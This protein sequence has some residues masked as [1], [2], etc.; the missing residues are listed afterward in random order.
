MTWSSGE[1][2]KGSFAVIDGQHGLRSIRHNHRNGDPSR[3]LDSQH[4]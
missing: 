4:M 2:I 1:G 3:G